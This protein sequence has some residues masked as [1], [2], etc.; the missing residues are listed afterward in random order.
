[1]G[2]RML[3][4]RT[5]QAR[6]TAQADA[7]AAPSMPPSR[8]PALAA[9]ASTARIP[10]DLTAAVRKAAV[11]LRHRLTTGAFRADRVLAWRQ[12]ADLGRGYLALLLTLLPRPRPP[13]RMTV[14]VATLIERP[15]GSAPRGRHRER[16][17]PRPDATP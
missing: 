9:D 11:S 2:I 13:R 10:T 4:R 6:N 15:Y 7:A 12:W 8:I 1:M 3:H 17:E 16:R 5:V 14:F